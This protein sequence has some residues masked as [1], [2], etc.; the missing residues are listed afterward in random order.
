MMNKL[1]LELCCVKLQSDH[2]LPGHDPISGLVY[3]VGL[4]HRQ[5]Q[6]QPKMESTA[7]GF[8]DMYVS[9]FIKVQLCSIKVKRL[10]IVWTV[11]K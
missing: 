7:Q 3:F 5:N 8:E 9:M 2:G 6:N 1:K 11:Q 4:T 10:K